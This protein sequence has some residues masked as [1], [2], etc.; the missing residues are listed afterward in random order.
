M[1]FYKSANDSPN[2]DPRDS[3]DLFSTL[4][5]VNEESFGIDETI[6]E[7]S[8]LTKF[9]NDVPKGTTRSSVEEL[10]NKRQYP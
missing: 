7:K 4:K 10:I 6:F 3:F 2:K 8:N 1:K 9:I 5:S